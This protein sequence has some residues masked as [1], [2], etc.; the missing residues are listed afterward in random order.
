MA[1][2]LSATVD[3]LIPAAASVDGQ[4]AFK[5]RVSHTKSPTDPNV[6]SETLSR[7]FTVAYDAEAEERVETIHFPVYHVP[8]AIEVERVS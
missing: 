3:V 6:T 8:F 5:V 1:G 7:E 4:V 2:R